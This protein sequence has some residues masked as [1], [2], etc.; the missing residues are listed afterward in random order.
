MTTPLGLGVGFE[1]PLFAYQDFEYEIDGHL[2]QELDN[3]EVSSTMLPST[4]GID[5]PISVIGQPAS[6]AKQV[7]KNNENEN[8]VENEND[9]FNSQ[10]WFSEYEEMINV[11]RKK[12]NTF[13]AS[14]NKL[15]LRNH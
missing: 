11:Q 5:N 7:A 1:N 14:S 12:V 3:I 10:A 2:C 9:D 4:S 8:K 13:V 6:S 15:S